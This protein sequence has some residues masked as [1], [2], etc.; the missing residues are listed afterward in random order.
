MNSIIPQYAVLDQLSI[1]VFIVDAEF[2]IQF[3]NTWMANSSQLS[4]ENVVG[5]SLFNLYPQLI[6]SRLNHALIASK[7]QKLPSVLSRVF[8]ASPLPLF[9]QAKQL[10]KQSITVKPASMCESCSIIQVIDV[11]N[12]VAREK[13]LEKQVLERQRAEAAK[14]A[15][16]ANMSHEIRT[17]LNGVIGMLE[18][19]AD[20]PLSDKLQQFLQI[21]SNSAESLLFIINDILDFSKIEAGK[22]DIDPVEFELLTF[23]EDIIA[24]FIPAANKKAISL[25]FDS[26]HLETTLV[27]A[28]K[29]RVR[30][31]LVNL[32]SNAIKFT[33]QGEVVVEVY[34]QKIDSQ[35]AQLV[36]KVLDT[37]IG[38]EAHVIAKLFEPFQQSDSSIS[39]RFGGTGLGLAIAKQLCH[40]MGGELTLSSKVG[41]GSCFEFEILLVTE[42]IPSSQQFLHT[43]RCLIAESNRTQSAL[44]QKQLETWG[45]TVIRT[46][47]STQTG[48]AL[49][50]NP[51][52]DHL[53]IAEKLFLANK[54]FINTWQKEQQGQVI[55]LQDHWQE[56]LDKYN[57]WHLTKPLF[58]T[59]ILSVLHKH[60]PR[61][62]V[63]L[64]KTA[65]A[66]Q[67]ANTSRNHQCILVVEDNPI[68][69]IVA[70]ECL[71]KLGYQYAVVEHGQAALDY[72]NTHPTPQINLILMDCQ[73]PIMDGFTATAKIRAGEAT[74][75]YQHIP[76]LALTANVIESERERCLQIGMNDFLAKPISLDIL[77]SLLD[78][79][80][81]AKI[82]QVN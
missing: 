56:S 51:R 73:M 78:K 74:E 69:Q 41:K 58:K 43:S 48:L 17:P 28:D 40:L 15:F 12:A 82:Q 35:T 9:N 70:K 57:T 37:G 39:R 79:W 71:K 34:L 68:N 38:I 46:F 21:A 18:L 61:N 62:T 59:Q 52:F 75:F 55:V 80:L 4:A 24:S 66:K 1:G 10:I 72:L 36:C 47:D 45:A 31:I 20:E 67:T 81:M 23:F 63:S 32:L 42:N 64:P 2:N 14:S 8:N 65:S 6:N 60:R 50:A 19:V 5:Q 22:V 13:A 53:F 11:S 26:S 27:R 25:I 49:A 16:L 44:L 30:Q 54:I 29:Q 33:E 77:A 7:E 76:I 3:W